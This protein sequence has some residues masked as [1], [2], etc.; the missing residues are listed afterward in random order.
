MPTGPKGQNRPADVV[1][2]A[3]R[4][5]QI[6]TGEV[7]EIVV[8][9]GKDPYAKALGAKGG[10]KRAASLSPERRKEIAKIAAK[11]RWLPKDNH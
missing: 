7:E 1:G 3:V 10:K 2:N 8:D 5:M 9:D 11:K 4:V 6:A